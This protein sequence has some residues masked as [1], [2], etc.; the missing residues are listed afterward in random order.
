VA[1][2]AGV[3]A[4]RS[5]IGMAAP[6]V[7]SA[8]D[9]R[10]RRRG[11]LLG[12]GIFTF[13]AAL[14]AVRPAYLPFV[15]AMLLTTV[16]KIIFDP[17]MQA[18]L[19]DRVGYD[20]RGQAIAVTEVGW[21]LAFL[22]GVP[23]MGWLIARGGWSAPFPWLAL[24]GCASAL[25]LWRIL[26][27]DRPRGDEP[28]LR[29]GLSQLLRS[30][31]PLA[32]LAFAALAAGANETINIVFGVWLEASFGLRVAIL[33]AAAAVI[34]L[35]ELSGEGLVAGITDRLGKRRS[36]AIGL[37][38]NSLACLALPY[39]A[40]TPASALVALFLFYLSFEFTVVSSI[41]MMTEL[42]PEA[43][44]TLMSVNISAFSLGRAIGAA[45]GLALF[46]FGI[47][48]N[49]LAVV[50]LNLTALVVLLAFIG[51]GPRSP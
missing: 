43:R 45:L 19:G 28:S 29:R 17:A 44:A 20:R 15:A 35:A 51:R 33:G 24:A 2:L 31:A 4:L 26:A 9:R 22:V 3:V 42:F 23:L 1:E 34:G 36:L 30:P 49:T 6:F 46:R 5:A 13:G 18:Y 37:I 12:L 40:R 8:A 50:A 11:M 47:G 21:S 39:L 38:G 25:L 7:G 27:P 16:G 41:P 32:G 10:G 48:A 14:V